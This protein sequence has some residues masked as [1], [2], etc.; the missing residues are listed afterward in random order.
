MNIVHKKCLYPN[1]QNLFYS[2]VHLHIIYMLGWAWALV[3]VQK[4]ENNTQE[5]LLPV[6]HVCS[7]GQTQIIRFEGKH[8]Y[9][10]SHITGKYKNFK[11]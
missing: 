8:L 5:W 10:L 3:C 4:S 2:F 7:E 9:L 11:T 6:H 1:L